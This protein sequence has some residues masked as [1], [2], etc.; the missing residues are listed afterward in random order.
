MSEGGGAIQA[1]DCAI[2]KVEVGSC[3]I[4]HVVRARGNWAFF[5]RLDARANVASKYVRPAQ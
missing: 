4:H 2:G 3:G 5:M 1:Y